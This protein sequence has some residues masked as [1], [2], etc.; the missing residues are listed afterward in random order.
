[1]VDDSEQLKKRIEQL[2]KEQ[3]KL[4]HDVNKSLL[5]I[6]FY[7][8]IDLYFHIAREIKNECNF[9]LLKEY[10]VEKKVI[11]DFEDY[12]NF[13]KNHE[14][15]RTYQDENKNAMKLMEHFKSMIENPAPDPTLINYVNFSNLVV[16]KNRFEIKR[17]ILLERGFKEGSDMIK[18][19][20]ELISS[21]QKD[22]EKLKEEK[23]SKPI[24]NKEYFVKKEDAQKIFDN[25]FVKKDEIIERIREL[26]L[27]SD[28]HLEPHNKSIYYETISNY[29][30]GN[31]N[32][33]IC[34]LSVLLESF[35]KEIYYYKE[36]K[37]F[38][39][40]IIPLINECKTQNYITEEQK[41]LLLSFA[42]TIRNKYLHASLNEIL[43][44]V[45]VP[46]YKIDFANP[47]KKP[48][49]TYCTAESLPTIRSIVKYDVDKIR[50]RKLIIQSVKIIE[51]ITTKNYD[52]Q[53]KKS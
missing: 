53:K 39:G 50:S 4:I 35:L 22:I 38:D 24:K 51:E 43:P 31:F 3:K 18:E 30:L 1:M 16:I 5:D 26:P 36:R 19:I 52:F 42:D 45:I 29:W 6:S 11:V 12:V 20:D 47:S 27:M 37:H 23:E 34:M 40:T 48:E 10:L 44:E 49:P 14:L 15:L 21:T 17:K 9:D 8:K 46:A 33:S 13:R 2:E 28:I 32:A 25:L 41:K 7:P